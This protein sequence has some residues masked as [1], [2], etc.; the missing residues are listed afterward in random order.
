MTATIALTAAEITDTRLDVI[1]HAREVLERAVSEHGAWRGS[2]S[3]FP[4]TAAMA[5]LEGAL[6]SWDSAAGGF[7]RDEAVETIRFWSGRVIAI[8]KGVMGTEAAVYVNCGE[9]SSYE[10]DEAA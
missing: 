2:A 1:S 10:G 8:I 6:R 5:D 4:V 7:E 3:L 9:G